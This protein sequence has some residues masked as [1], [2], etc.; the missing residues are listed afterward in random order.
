[1]SEQEKFLARWSRR[2]L[3][4]AGDEVAAEPPA[5]CVPATEQDAAKLAAQQPTP[6]FDVSTLPPLESIS[7]QSDISVFLQAGVPTA[8]KHAALRRAWSADPA[9][10]DF[11]GLNENFWEGADTAGVP[12][13]GPLDP[14]FD[15]KKLVAEMFGEG[16]PQ[17]QSKAPEVESGAEQTAGPVPSAPASAAVDNAS[18]H[19][20]S[21]AKDSDTV[22]HR[23]E[24]IALQQDAPSEQ[25][26]PSRP[27][28]HGGALPR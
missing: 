13:F 28:R 17:A 7:A 4:P 25:A 20:Q 27:T 3:A 26:M 24:H 9:V 14:S 12:G 16:E 18:S 8:L 11:V 22:L 1:M 23:E 5:G 21:G 10:R 2:K 6:E 19:P 15:V